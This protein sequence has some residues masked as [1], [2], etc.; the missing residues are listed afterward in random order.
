MPKST[1]AESESASMS[2]DNFDPDDG[3]ALSSLKKQVLGSTS[4]LSVAAQAATATSL[5]ANEHSA[6]AH[7]IKA[8]DV[9]RKQ[10]FALADAMK[11]ADLLRGQQSAL[12]PAAKLVDLLPKEPPYLKSLNAIQTAALHDSSSRL[13]AD[14]NKAVA[15]IRPTHVDH[16]KTI[17]A[18]DFAQ[19]NKVAGSALMVGSAAEVLGRLPKFDVQSYQLAASS[20]A[21]AG[22]LGNFKAE[23]ASTRLLDGVAAY[24]GA[25]S[26][27]AG[28]GVPDM[29]RG[30]SLPGATVVDSYLAGLGARPLARRASLAG[31]ATQSVAGQMIS[32]ALLAPDLDEA[33]LEL[34]VERSDV[35]VLE[36]WRQGQADLQTQLYDEL[37]RIN[38]AIPDRLK[39]AWEDIGRDGP[40]AVSKAANC[41]VEALDATLHALCEGADLLVWLAENGLKG[42]RYIAKGH[43]TRAARAAFASRSRSRRD[44]RLVTSLEDGVVT[45]LVA[46][47]SA[48][49]GSKHERIVISVAASG[50]R[51]HAASAEALL[52]ALLGL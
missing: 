20:S 47:I 3:V 34:L 5:L 44:R 36:P 19:F 18:L 11:A 32:E 16:F 1:T 27:I 24:A 38:P 39:G 10:H 15:G 42:E 4:A 46:L 2:A 7:A 13:L 9:L 22:I 29:L 52:A 12:L 48:V 8:S 14:I 28:T 50:I 17:A 30:L 35:E 33:H 41:L 45:Q 26:L 37:H 23:V 51:S 21:I 31:V 49:E 40:A 43:P 6:L 25:N